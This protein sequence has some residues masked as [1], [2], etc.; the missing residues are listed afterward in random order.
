MLFD[1]RRLLEG[2]G[3]AAGALGGPAGRSPPEKEEAPRKKNLRSALRSSGLSVT[4]QE[5]IKSEGDG[6]VR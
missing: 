2:I 5:W 1:V 6:R 4:E 3:R